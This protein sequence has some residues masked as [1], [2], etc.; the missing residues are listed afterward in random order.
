MPGGENGHKHSV[1]FEGCRFFRSADIF[2]ELGEV[3][4]KDNAGFGCASFTTS[5]H[6]CDRHG[7]TGSQR[8]DNEFDF[9]GEVLGTDVWTDAQLSRTTN[10]I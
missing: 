5:K 2:Y 7:L 4:Q 9:L 8:A 10:V 6:N 3:P 1:A